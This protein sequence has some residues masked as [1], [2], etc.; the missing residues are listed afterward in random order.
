[1]SDGVLFPRNPL[2]QPFVMASPLSFEIIW[3]KD[4]TEKKRKTKRRRTKEVRA[5]VAC[6]VA[7]AKFDPQKTISLPSQMIIF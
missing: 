2:L 4:S 5:A 7:H 6:H 1:M 3:K